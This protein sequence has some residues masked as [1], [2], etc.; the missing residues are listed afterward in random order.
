M[1]KTHENVFPGAHCYE[2]S[3][4]LS[5]TF[6]KVN[7]ILPHFSWILL[8]GSKVKIQNHKI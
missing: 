6:L 3:R 1:G 2:N 5:E 4:L 8:S 7:T